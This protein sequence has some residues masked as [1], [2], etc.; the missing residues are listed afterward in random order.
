MKFSKE[1]IEGVFKTTPNEESLLVFQAGGEKN[2]YTEYAIVHITQPLPA[3]AFIEKWI[4]QIDRFRDC[5]IYEG[6]RPL[7]IRL[8]KKSYP[9]E[10]VEHSND[11]TF[12]EVKNLLEK[13]SVSFDVQKPPLFKVIIYKQ[14]DSYFFCLAYHHLLFDGLSVQLALSSL[15]PLNNIQ[16]TDW[17]PP[18]PTHDRAFQSHQPFFLEEFVPPPAETKENYLW[19]QHKIVDKT[20]EELMCAW[21]DFIQKATGKKEIIVG[22]VFSARTKYAEANTALGYYVQTWPLVF[23]ET[24]TPATLSSIRKDIQLISD[25]YVKN[26]FP[27]N[28]FDHCWVVEPYIQSSYQTAFFSTPHYLLTIVIKQKA[29]ELHVEFCW[30]LEKIDRVAAQQIFTSFIESIDASEKTQAI[31]KKDIIAYDSVLQRWKEMVS[32]RKDATAVEDASGK[33][34]SYL[35]VDLLSNRLANSLQIIPGECVGVHTTYSVAIPISFLAILKKG[36]IYVPLDPTVSEE[37]RTYILKDAGI[38]TVISDINNQLGGI[39]IHPLQDLAESV[40]IEHTACP[41]ET[42]YLIYTSGTT[43]NPK[44]CAVNHKNLLNLFLGTQSLFQFQIKDRWIL[45]HSYGFDF[46]TWEIWGPLLHGAY[47]YI[48]QRHEVQDTFTFHELLAKKEITVLN[49]TPKAFYNLLLTDE[50]GRGLDKIRYVIFGGD[51]LQS[52]RLIPWMEKYAH[53][54][55]INMYGIT[56]TTVHVTF[57]EV[58]PESQSNIGKPLPGYEIELVNGSNHAVPLGFI[59]EI[60][61]YGNGVCNGYF[62]KPELTLQKFGE[63]NNRAYYRSGDLAWQIGDHYYYLGRKDRQIKIRGYRIELGEIEFLLKKKIPACDFQVLFHEQ[64]LY[65]FYKGEK[66]SLSS[67]D[68]RGYMADYSVPSLFHYLPEFPLNQ[69]GKIDEKALIQYIAHDKKTINVQ[70]NDEII[71]L[72]DDTLGIKTDPSRS[73]LQNGGDSISAIRFINKLKKIGKNISV[74]DLFQATPLSELRISSVANQPQKNQDHL[75]IFHR[76][77]GLQ[78][79]EH[80]F[81]F[82][83]LES[84]HGILIDCLKQENPSLYVE[85]LTYTIPSKYNY[86]QIVK[87]Y[88]QVCN[89]NPILRSRIERHNEQYFFFVGNFRPQTCQRIELHEF[90]SRLAADYQAGFELSESLSR[91]TVAI[92]EETN[93]II[94]THHHL[95]LDGWSLGLF[96]KQMIA[97]LKNLPLAY[98][99]GFI[100]KSCENFLRLKNNGYWA[101]LNNDHIEEAFV[102]VLSARNERHEYKKKLYSISFTGHEKCRQQNITNYHFLFSAWTAFVSLLFSK[103]NIALGN[104]VSLRTADD[105]EQMGMYIRSLPFFTSFDK[106]ERFISYTEKM[107]SLL[108]QDEAH[109]EEEFHAFIKPNHLTHLF[110]FE[111]YPVDYQLLQKENIEIGSFREMTGAAWTTIV[112]T[113]ENGFDFSILYDTASYS[114]S[115]VDKIMYHFSSWLSELQWNT[116]MHL[117]LDSISREKSL[118]G[119]HIPDNHNNIIQ[120]LRRDSKNP[121]IIGKDETTTYEALWTMADELASSIKSQGLISGEAVGIDVSSTLHFVCAILATWSAG[122]VPCP[123]DSRYPEA[124]K[125]FIYENASVRFLLVSDSG[126]LSL[127]NR[128][129]EQKTHPAGS[130]FILHTSGSTGQP[131]GVVQTMRCLINLIQWNKKEFGISESEK[132]L[133]LSSFGFDASFHEI[134]LALSLG[135][136][137]IEVPL[138]SRLDIHEIKKHI[139][140]YG[141][142]MCWIPARVLNAVLDVEPQFFDDCVLLKKIVTTGEAL[143]LGSELKKWITRSNVQLL[144]Y[145]GPTETH[146]VTAFAVEAQSASTRPSI[147]IVLTNC[148][149]LLMTESGNPAFNGLPGEIWV[150]GDHLAIEYL[151]DELQTKSR[152]VYFDNKRWYKT[153]DW[154]YRDEKDYL[155]YIGRKDDQLKIRGFRVEPLEVERILMELS[156]VNQCCI[157]AVE[158]QLVAFVVS[159]HDID[160]IKEKALLQLPDYMMPSHWIFLEKMPINNNGKADRG[161]LVTIFQNNSATEQKVDTKKISFQCWLDVLEHNRFS[162]NTRFD[163]AGGNSIL[164]MKM[165]AWIEKNTGY[166]VSIRELITNNTPALL[167]I[168][169]STKE[170]QETIQHLPE[171]FPLNPLQRSMLI[172]EM[173]NNLGNYSPFILSFRVVLKKNIT[174]EKWIES[175]RALLNK[176]P[177]LIFTLKPDL[178]VDKQMWSKKDFSDTVFKPFEKDEMNFTQPLIRFVYHGELEAEICWHHILLDGLGIQVLMEHLI[179][180][181]DGNDH[182]KRIPWDALMSYNAVH[183]AANIQTERKKAIKETISISEEQI[184]NI[185]FFCK[186]NKIEES[187]FLF[188]MVSRVHNN[189]TIAVTDVEGHPGIPGMFT[190][191]KAIDISWNGNLPEINKSNSSSRIPII[192]NYMHLESDGEWINKIISSTP[193]YTKYPYEWQFIKSAGDLEITFYRSE[194]DVMAGDYFSKLLQ[195]IDQH[196]S[197]HVELQPKTITPSN[198]FEDF[199]F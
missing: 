198:S 107:A 13:D 43:G 51:K 89:Q 67:D 92:G 73:F 91:I 98:S 76:Q 72:F 36:G 168:L 26:H 1:D 84:Q 195:N 172:S 77:S 103:K 87:A 18:H 156:E 5:Y 35:E 4:D 90:E 166:F 116:P 141:G 95:I 19:L 129:S 41:T 53:C 99:D 178:D 186:K 115:Y 69:S 61:V 114:E 131:K 12:D 182:P 47:L 199:D 11:L 106:E 63:I 20:Y 8:Q 140:S 30:N 124:R 189:S 24:P 100:Q 135:A 64:K 56:E 45:A 81:Y 82:P 3:V 177:Y 78:R 123:V 130:G 2:R 145:Y 155:H 68:F 184:K 86:Q 167:E 80:T 173:G 170:Q 188:G 70:N 113:V 164:L 149:I 158:Q 25:G 127:I 42:C 110:V 136:S 150:A 16:Y 29:T 133:Q 119:P 52:Q 62:Q 38:K 139:L 175:V 54:R 142:T 132:I 117:T 125:K 143:V 57:Y 6:A 28:T 165:Q 111:N 22:E 144:N 146:V 40:V 196:M 174:N 39:Q 7:R 71:A 32:L 193:D 104:V 112:Y 83:L 154:A 27:S 74:Q 147:G 192:A 161:Q 194:E 128:K 138:E 191:L 10:I 50:T 17:T 96:S 9:I 157:L 153:G 176:F 59:G 134:L 23:N 79:T 15:Q 151:N 97:A 197:G 102:P 93:K 190:S 109:K 183:T 137:L 169:L 58:K 121:A 85:Q 94:W 108:Q 126:K 185:H 180:I 88:E 187:V 181:L 120:I 49:Q 162:V 179:K 44:G 152:F 48:P 101:K 37:R 31:D 148:E 171:E 159:A 55:M 163:Q 65:A 46:S 60:I 75:E 105:M 66:V 21:V 14:T 160:Q 34:F 122:G 33:T 118:Q